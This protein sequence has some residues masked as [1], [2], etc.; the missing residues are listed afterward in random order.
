LGDTI[1]IRQSSSPEAVIS[2]VMTDDAGNTKRTWFW[3]NAL[4]NLTWDGTDENGNKVP[5][6]MYHYE[7][8]ATDAAGNRS[9]TSLHNI[10]VDTVVTSVYLTAKNSLFSPLSEEF[11]SQIF[12]VHV[13][14]NKGIENW[15]LRIKDSANAVV[16][17]IQGTTTIPSQL[18]WDGR[19]DNGTL[20]EGTFTGELEVIYRKGNRPVALSREFIVDNSAP[21]ISLNLSPVPFSP[22]DDNVE[23]ELKMA[24]T[25]R[26][27]SPIRDWNMTIRDPKG[28]EFITFGG[29]G[30]PS[31]R[32]IWDGRSRQGELVQSAEDYPYEIRVTDFLGHSTTE[33]G[34]I[35]VDIL[36]IR[37]GDRLK[38]RISN[39]TFQPYKALLVSTGEQ[40]D[41][42]Q[43]ILK[44]LSEVLKK[45]GSYS[46]VIEGHAVSEYYDNPARA[47]REE[48]EELQPLSLTRA[49][50]VKEY[51]RTLGIQESRMDVIGKGGT[52]PVVPHS[53]L[54]NR[55]KNRRVEFIL[56]K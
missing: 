9:E 54:E 47:A 14:N 30:R 49:A 55:W 40:G 10:E 5:D 21:L 13:T 3:K 48:K 53:D 34:L 8:V 41:K 45:Y 26:D 29:K 38:V 12:T 7:L 50:T 25:V 44:R 43:D 36:V 46:I 51:L 19:S 24:L 37:D 6:G 17:S 28:K 56:I 31:E 52:E 27:L 32:I 1:L 42:N 39:I 35:P 4:E 11:N 18:S 23:D 20:Q 15:T 22:D 16:K 2:A 33:K